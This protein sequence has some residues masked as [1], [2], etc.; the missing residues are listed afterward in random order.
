MLFRS[1]MANA[2]Q[3]MPKG[4]HL[5]LRVYPKVV[6]E[7]DSGVGR[8]ATDFFKVGD[9]VV[10]CDVQDSGEG[11]SANQIKKI[12]D[13]FFTTKCS[14]KGTGLGL[15]LV[16]AIIDAHRGLISVTS[17]EGRGTVFSIALPTVR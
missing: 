15:T 10:V 11:I 1:L 2:L 13:P 14:G 8:R 9:T 7:T 6:C 12:F 16:R 17:Q 4:G 5:S 3:A